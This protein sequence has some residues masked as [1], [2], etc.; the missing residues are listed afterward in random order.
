MSTKQDIN[1]IFSQVTNTKI[2][3]EEFHVFCYI[4]MDKNE[5]TYYD[6]ELISNK[7]SLPKEKVKKAIEKLK[8]EDLINKN[9]EIK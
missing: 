3:A 8:S 9:L 4:T 2:S 7:I 1:A 5:T 6:S